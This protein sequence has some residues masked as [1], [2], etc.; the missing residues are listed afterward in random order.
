MLFN[1]KYSGF[2][3]IDDLRWH[4][5]RCHSDEI[6]GVVCC[7]EFIFYVGSMRVEGEQVIEIDSQDFWVFVCPGLILTRCLLYSIVVYLF[8][9]H[10]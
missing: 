5:M 10:L 6:Y 1:G 9:F 8:L 3:G 7:L 2:L 4:D